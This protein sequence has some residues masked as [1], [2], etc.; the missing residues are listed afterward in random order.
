[1][2]A[3]DDGGD[4]AVV[5]S[6]NAGHVVDDMLHAEL[7]N[8]VVTQERA[9]LARVQVVGIVG[10]RGVLR[11][12]YLL[13]R[14]ALCAQVRLEAHEVG[15]GRGGVALDPPCDQVGLRVALR[16]HE[17]MEIVVVLAAIDPALELRALLER[18]VAPANELGLADANASQRVAHGRP[19][20][21]THSD[22]TDIR[23]FEQHDREPT[24]RAR[25]M[26]GRDDAGGQP[27]GRSAADDH[28]SFHHM[29]P[30]SLKKEKPLSSSGFSGFATCRLRKL[31][32]RLY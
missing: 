30:H 1:M 14:L 3:G 29:H 24:T 7:V 8:A 13:G 32:W 31:A 28:E 4:I 27:T 18:R 17:G 2:I 25:A 5:R 9:E 12:R 21:L 10:D 23:R 16:H 19:R 26:F 11:R 6:F 22:G 20:A 15:E